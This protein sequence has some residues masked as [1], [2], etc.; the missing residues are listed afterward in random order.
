MTFSLAPSAKEVAASSCFP[1]VLAGLSVPPSPS[2]ST[3]RYSPSTL[4]LCRELQKDELT[5]LEV[6][7]LDLFNHTKALS[8]PRRLH[9]R[10]YTTQ[11]FPII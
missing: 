3:S 4:E 7:Y 10:P 1:P 2:A 5:A 9:D 8:D 6:K 11:R